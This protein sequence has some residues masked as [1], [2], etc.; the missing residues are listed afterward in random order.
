MS[1]T[2]AAPP[3]TL[4]QTVIRKVTMRLMP[5]MFLMYIFNYL[6]RTNLSFARIKFQGDLHMSDTAFGVGA[7]IFFAGYFLF[8]VP[9]NLVMQRVGARKWMARI[10][11]SWGIISSAMMFTNSTMTFYTLRFLLGVAEAGFFPGMILYLTYWFPAVERARA[12]A[13]FMTATAL[14]GA[15]GGP[16][17]GLLL[18][19]M[20]GVGRLKGWQW[21]FLV[22]GIPS[23]ILGFVTYFY[24]TDRPEQAHWLSADEKECLRLRLSK[25][26]DRRQTQQRTGLIDAFRNPRTRQVSGICVIAAIAIYCYFLL[27]KV[28][29]GS[30]W[31]TLAVSLVS[32]IPYLIAIIAMIVVHAQVRLLCALYFAI[33]VGAYGMTF[34]LPK[35]L[36]DFHLS[37]LG[38]GFVSAI[39]YLLAAGAMVVVAHLSDRSCER[40]RWVAACASLA[41]IGLVCTALAISHKVQSPIPG[42]VGICLVSIGISSSMGPFWSLPTSF[43]TGAGAAGGIALINSVGNLGGQL[44]PFMMGKAEDLTKSNAAGLYVLA[45]STTIAVI[46]SFIVHHDRSLERPHDTEA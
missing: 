3:P 30:G 9:S 34:W 12:V 31:S 4:E 32:T 11:V 46:L 7:G 44:G 8:E 21:L 2:I 40:K 17:S 10:M 15:F 29:S 19:G 26:E 18:S 16:V 43:L 27:P 23:F 24:L 36:S 37:I 28:L 22:E 39:P 42:I 45:G 5:Y 38:V 1:T 41:T 13:R 20:D 33:V 35:L 14:A 6:D 25:E